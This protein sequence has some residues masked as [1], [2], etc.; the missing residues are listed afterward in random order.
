MSQSFNTASVKDTNTE[1]LFVSTNSN[2][3][4]KF[5]L[6]ALKAL[7]RDNIRDGSGN[8]LPIAGDLS[9][10]GTDLAYDFHTVNMIN[11][12]VFSSQI[13]IVHTTYEQ[14]A[15]DLDA[16]YIDVSIGSID[17]SRIEIDE[18]TAA[19]VEG[20]LILDICNGADDISLSNAGTNKHNLKF[21]STN[22]N[23]KVFTKALLA[24]TDNSDTSLLFSVVEDASNV[25]D[26]ILNK[27]PSSGAGIIDVSN[28]FDVS[29][30]NVNATALSAMPNQV[31]YGLYKLIYTTG[32]SVTVTKIPDI[33]AIGM[34]DLSGNILPSVYDGDTNLQNFLPGGS[35]EVPNYQLDIS[36]SQGGNITCGNS[37]FTISNFSNMVNNLDYM[38]AIR[39]FGTNKN[40]LDS[41]S[42]IFLA[43]TDVSSHNILITNSIVDLSFGG[44]T[45][46]EYTNGASGT[47]KTFINNTQDEYLTDSSQGEIKLFTRADTSRILITNNT[48]VSNVFT[49]STVRYVGDASI[50][51]TNVDLCLNSTE[52]VTYTVKQKFPNPGS[53]LL[54]SQCVSGGNLANVL[55]FKDASSILFANNEVDASFVT[56]EIT[57]L[58][59]A[60]NITFI[61]VTDENKF[62]TRVNKIFDLCNT[63]IS[64]G[65]PDV[66]ISVTGQNVQL[67]INGTYNYDQVRLFLEP[68]TLADISNAGT[69]LVA[70]ASGFLGF[71]TT[72]SATELKTKVDYSRPLNEFTWNV[73]DQGTSIDM[74][75]DIVA[76]YEGDISAHE[77]QSKI[78]TLF[79]KSWVSGGTLKEDIDYPEDYT[80]TLL[81][82]LTDTNTNLAAHGSGR[83]HEI[84]KETRNSITDPFYLGAYHN[85]QADIS[86]IIIK[87]TYYEYYH[88]DGTKGPESKLRNYTTNAAKR[89]ITYT[90]QLRTIT[91]S[92]LHTMKGQLQGRDKDASVYNTTETKYDIDLAYNE[93]TTITGFNTDA[94]ATF[95][96]N[97]DLDQGDVS[98]NATDYAI[99]LDFAEGNATWNLSKKTGTLSDM[100]TGLTSLQD[101]FDATGFATDNSLSSFH[102]VH[103]VDDNTGKNTLTLKNS[104]NSFCTI[105]GDKTLLANFVVVVANGPVFQVLRNGDDISFDNYMY[106]ETSTLDIDNGIRLTIAPDQVNFGATDASLTLQKDIVGVAHYNTNA[107]DVSA[108]ISTS[109]TYTDASAQDISFNNYRGIIAD[110]TIQIRR[111]GGKFQLDFS[112]VTQNVSGDLLTG[113]TTDASMTDFSDISMGDLGY[114]ITTEVSHFGTSNALS[115]SLTTPLTITPAQYKVAGTI[116]DTSDNMQDKTSFS[117]VLFDFHQAV[118]G[119]N[120]R[121]DG[122]FKASLIPAVGDGDRYKVFSDSGGTYNIFKG[123]TSIGSSSAVKN[124]EIDISNQLSFDNVKYPFIIILNQTVAN[125]VDVSFS[126]SQP[127]YQVQYRNSTG[128][129]NFPHS[130][131]AVDNTTTEFLSASTE[132]H[133]LQDIS[134]T[135]TLDVS[136]TFID[137]A[138]NRSTT[139][140]STDMS[141]NS[142]TIRAQVTYDA[143]INPSIN[144]EFLVIPNSGTDT[145][146][147]A[148]T[149]DKITKSGRYY[150]LAMTQ[151]ADGLY[152]TYDVCSNLVNTAAN[153]LVKIPSAYINEGRYSSV[154]TPNIGVKTSIIGAEYVL[155]SDV[156]VI[157]VRKY[158]SPIHESFETFKIDK[159]QVRAAG[160]RANTIEEATIPLSTATFGSTAYSF[161]TILN[162]TADNLSSIPTYTT[163]NKTTISDED[164]W[165]DYTNNKLN[166]VMV[167]LTFAGIGNIFEVTSASNIKPVKTLVSSTPDITRIT[168][169]DGAPVFRVRANGRIDTGAIQTANLIS[170]DSQTSNSGSTYNKEFVSYNVLLG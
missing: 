36:L 3:A 109:K 57:T 113:T 38:N 157:K 60:N 50:N 74:S 158:T 112:G 20:T 160:F 64:F 28:L 45:S 118:V 142:N 122:I 63:D 40:T 167:P 65:N 61:K 137:F 103:V 13:H 108:G 79:K 59:A 16:S 100:V 15:N 90:S 69:G 99:L 18:T 17:I 34:R 164:I 98:L 43:H 162:T 25:T 146:S 4:T 153:I 92:M 120:N 97:L 94:S 41:S 85:L 52:T 22:V 156:P 29:L 67:D 129:T 143:S 166:Y 75:F 107:I 5:E 23:D 31:E 83:V 30:D 73:F 72:D 150:E 96:I 19:F 139:V 155:S 89:E 91:K 24:A 168:S 53:S 80:L 70:D 124:T 144:D 12:D 86:N 27:A 71:S 138:T 135:I 2:D 159:N 32:A 48:D 136:K 148:V 47:F 151:T 56:S 111:V 130:G 81:E 1:K 169:A 14:R 33:N 82:T 7:V 106:T 37:A 116:A 8:V 119:S 88:S 102:T 9:G 55:V 170:V 133:Q 134:A 149:I 76:N 121:T 21:T 125:N 93:P 54:N 131:N 163:L 127:K 46:T 132:S 84:V 105:E 26:I 147:V 6:Q 115:T 140:F 44:S 10:T 165:D 35:A 11:Q 154:I 87:D 42:T 114:D 145:S 161:Q 126:I 117:D 141:G 77:F 152:T 95:T 51:N 39:D 110:Q 123:G 128:V 58:Q 49:A 68:K 62:A 66:Q 78:Q 104:D 101:I